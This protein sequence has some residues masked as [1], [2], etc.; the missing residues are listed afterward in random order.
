METL[1]QGN[2]FQS[3][4][5]DHPQRG[6]SHQLLLDALNNIVAVYLKQKQYHK[7]KLAS[8]EV[9]QVDPHNLKALLRAA[10]AAMLDPAS[11][12]EEAKAAIVAAESEITYKNPEE[13]KQLHKLKAL[14]K[15]KQQEYKDASKS[16][17]GN[18]LKSSSTISLSKDEQVASQ[19]VSLDKQVSD[20][21]TASKKP[22]INEKD[23]EEPLKGENN[24]APS[25]EIEEMTDGQNFWR[26]QATAAFVQVVIPLLIFLLYRYL[27]P[28]MFGLGGKTAPDSPMTKKNE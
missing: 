19:E 16:M 17:F 21:G 12:L 27:N 14:L 3:V 9:L 5:K 18:K 22:T 23:S 2:Y 4:E 1:L 28:E 15:K 13:E 6:E 7:A 10:K 26:K 25:K 20:T 8:V 11:T 24:Q